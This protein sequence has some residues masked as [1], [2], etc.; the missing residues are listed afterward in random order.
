LSCSPSPFC[1][2]NTL[3]ST[4]SSCRITMSPN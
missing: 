3:H 4:Q 2:W 1:F